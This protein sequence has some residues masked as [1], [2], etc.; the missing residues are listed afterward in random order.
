MF[1]DVTKRRNPG[2]ID[3]GLAL[4]QNGEIPPNTY[5]IDID[6]LKANTKKLAETAA[7]HEMKLYFMSKQLGRIPALAA[8]IAENGIDKAVAVDFDEGKVL[9]EHGFQ[10]GN[11]GHLVQPGKHQWKEVLS[12]QPEV[13]TTFSYE[14]ARQVAEA[15]KQAGVIQNIL[16]KV[17][18]E[19]DCI[20]EGQEG[21]ILL[22]E[23]SKIAERIQKLNGVRITGVTSFPNL[24]LTEDRTAMVPDRKSVV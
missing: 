18:G 24:K 17:V 15:A 20:Y 4:H 13:V 5:V 16:L 10:I 1:L 7:A 14:R 6:V 3:A 21:G 22:N 19:N 12:W 8:I 11:I 23:L 2:L 9:A